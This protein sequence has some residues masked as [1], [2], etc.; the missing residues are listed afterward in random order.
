MQDAPA[1]L[2]QETGFGCPTCKVHH[3]SQ[4]PVLVYVESKC[5]VCFEYD[6]AVVLDCKHAVCPKCF[7]ILRKRAVSAALREEQSAD[8]IQQ[9]HANDW[10][11][12][13]FPFAE[14][15]IGTIYPRG[16]WPM[17]EE[18]PFTVMGR[19]PMHPN[20]LNVKQTNVR[21]RRAL[22]CVE[23]FTVSFNLIGDLMFYLNLNEIYIRDEIS[24]LIPKFRDDF[25]A[26]HA[27]G[28]NMGNLIVVISTVRVEDMTYMEAI[29]N[30]FD[31]ITDDKTVDGK[32]WCAKSKHLVNSSEHW[33]DIFPT[34]RACKSC[35]NET[36]L[37]NAGMI[38][39]DCYNNNTV[40]TCMH[41][42][43]RII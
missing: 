30:I 29:S 20:M 37:L 39:E 38:C 40:E 15:A 27:R 6:N 31:Q 26:A 7:E 8:D 42:S 19:R 1:P 33:S 16:D 23:N 24:A 4:N 32:V 22:K 3:T 17:Y 5:Q 13:M 35:T 10:D 18:V 36:D 25:V 9:I 34:C 21:M 11:Y 41:G 43:N 14:H 12:V 28:V 2:Q